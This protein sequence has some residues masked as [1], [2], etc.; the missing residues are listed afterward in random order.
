MSQRDINEMLS[1]SLQNLNLII[2][3]SK[4]IGSP[5]KIDE[6]RIIIPLSKIT[7][8]F[9]VGGSEFSSKNEKI[10]SNNLIEN[11]SNYPFGGGTIGGVNIIPIAFLMI[12][13]DNSKIIRVEND[14]TLF[15]KLLELFLKFM[16]K[17]NKD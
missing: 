17:K 13:K 11:D 3:S 2:D 7:F 15:N 12:E 1:N 8:G 14:D 5:L 6:E 9:G 16:A 10:I 4:V